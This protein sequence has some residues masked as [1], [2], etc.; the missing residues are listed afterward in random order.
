M[1]PD[2]PSLGA[3]LQ[4]AVSAA[5]LLALC[6][7]AVETVLI[8][9]H[10]RQFL[11][12]PT[13][14]FGAQT[15]DFC[16]KLFLLLPGM[17][18][19][20]RGGIL[21]SFLAA[22]FTSK[23]SIGAALLLPNLVVAAVLGAAVG[24]VRWAMG[25]RAEVLPALL[26]L[27][28]LGFAV[29]L[30]SWISGIYVPK[31]WSA[32]VLLRQAARVLVWEGA[33]LAFASLAAAAVAAA[34]LGRLRPAARWAV[35]AGLAALLVGG[36]FTLAPSTADSSVRATS[37]AAPAPDK[38]VDNLILISIDSLRADRVHSYGNAHETS[39]TLDRIGSQGWRFGN[40]YSSSSWTLPSHMSMLTGR[41]VLGHGVISES[42]RLSPAVPT[43]AGR[44]KSAGLATAAIVS[45]PVLSSRF[46][47]NHGFDSYDDHTIPARNAFDA[48]KDEPAPTVE[49]LATEWL[50]EHAQER[51]FLFLHFWDVHYDYIPPAPYDTMF[52]P[53]Y[54]GT[55]TGANFYKDKAINKHLPQRDVEHLLALYDGEI[56][57]VD[58]HIARILATVEQL[59]LAGKTAVIITSDHGDEFFEHGYKGHG[60]TLYNEVTHV[61]LVMYVPG[62]PGGQVIDTTV[63]HVDL[64]PTVL[65]L[66]GAEAPA[67]L[68]GVDLLQ[69]GEASRLRERVAIDGWLCNLKVRS[70]CLAMQKSDA[71]TLIHLFQPLRLEFYA[72]ADVLQKKN[73]AGKSEWPRERQM[74]LL[75]SQLNGAW[76]SY[77]ELR[78]KRGE[79][80]LDAATRDRLRDLGYLDN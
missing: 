27:V 4:A 40:A 18:D 78:Q 9:A 61:P 1:S 65:A 33:W 56:R 76:K 59:G 49:K 19:W 10:A 32:K 30:L 23:L 46:G 11:I 38:V 34:L 12:S 62:L 17:G 42:D 41:D 36:I 64:M 52:D 55:V 69:T 71:G 70:D 50:R 35:S 28:G 20:F 45:T 57:W 8:A 44:L 72:P 51:F 73:L 80:E 43:L 15:Y 26:V 13:L 60:R 14:F 75:G 2:K 68:S 77:R 67:G 58:D 3:H 24:A 66:L 22:G 79:A 63:S 16:V 37:E 53:D 29:H 21:D 6:Q 25:R 74:S 5:V 48:V 31:G 7:V 47:F 39:P 54:K